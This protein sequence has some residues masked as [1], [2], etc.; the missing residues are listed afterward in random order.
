MRIWRMCVCVY[1]LQL[2]LWKT[3]INC[4]CFYTRCWFQSDYP[5][6]CNLHVYD[7][8]YYAAWC[9]V[10]TLHVH[11]A[12]STHHY[13]PGLACRAW[14]SGFQREL[15]Y[16]IPRLHYP[17]KSRRFTEMFGDVCNNNT[18][19]MYV[20]VENLVLPFAPEDFR[21]KPEPAPRTQGFTESSL[22]V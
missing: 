15:E 21:R 10:L 16:R 18:R 14:G 7:I 13:Q 12:V 9:C 1:V 20:F 11:P 22:R 5:R 4:G 6:C 8:N 19:F 3:R 2:Q 17:V